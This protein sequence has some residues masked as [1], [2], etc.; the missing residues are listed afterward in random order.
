MPEAFYP[1]AG[2]ALGKPAGPAMRVNGSTATF[3]RRF[4]HASVFVDLNN[5]SACRVDFAGCDHA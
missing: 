5:R 1:E 4:E 2:C 3:R